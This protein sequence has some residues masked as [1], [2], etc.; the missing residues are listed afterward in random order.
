MTN[1]KQIKI[2]SG[3]VTSSSNSVKELAKDLLGGERFDG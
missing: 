2:N 3:G 1:K